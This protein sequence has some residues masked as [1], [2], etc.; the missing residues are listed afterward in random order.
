M[1]HLR[2]LSLLVLCAACAQGNRGWVP[3]SSTPISP[4]VRVDTVCVNSEHRGRAVLATV[5]SG[6]TTPVEPIAGTIYAR[7]PP[8]YADERDWYVRGDW[9]EIRQRSLAR[10][11]RT[12]L[13]YPSDVYPMGEFD[14]IKLYSE[15]PND[16][17]F[18]VVLMP[19]SNGCEYAKYQ[20]VEQGYPVMEDPDEL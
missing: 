16:T 10:Y 20:L 19:I 17:S 7:M 15:F 8:P 2:D 6:D 18:E 5:T 4:L 9:I 13:K 3:D 14:G 1:H 12:Y 11:N